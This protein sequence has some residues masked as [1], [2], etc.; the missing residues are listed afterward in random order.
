MKLRTRNWTGKVA[1]VGDIR[2]KYR[3][4]VR[5]AEKDQLQYIS[6]GKY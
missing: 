1:G 3:F 5:K 2:N 6:I 4:F